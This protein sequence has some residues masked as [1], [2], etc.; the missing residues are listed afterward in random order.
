MHA[1]AHPVG[2][3]PMIRYLLALCLMLAAPA[4]AATW[5]DGGG[6]AAAPL[7][8]G[9]DGVWSV[10]PDKSSPN[11]SHATTCTPSSCNRTG[12]LPAPRGNGNPRLSPSAVF[13]KS[14]LVTG[15]LLLGRNILPWV[16]VGE[17]L[18]DWYK[19]A[20]L[21]PDPVT[22]EPGEMAGAQESAS[23][24]YYFGSGNAYIVA[25]GTFSTEAAAVQLVKSWNQVP[26]GSTFV[27][28]VYE[29]AY[30]VNGG[31]GSSRGRFIAKNNSNGVETQYCSTFSVA[32]GSLSQT[33]C[34][35][36]GTK[37]IMGNATGGLCP[38]GTFTPVSIATA[39]QRLNNADVTSDVLKRS[40]ED[41]LKAGGSLQDTGTHS[42]IGPSSVPG[43]TKTKTTTA[44][45]GTTQVTTVTN[46]YN[47]N[48]AGNT[49]TITTTELVQNPDGST[50][51]TTSD[52]P[53]PL[54]ADNPNSLACIKLG[55]VPTDQP[56]WETKTIAYQ[57]DSLGLPAACPAPWTGQLRG[58]T[59][60]FSYQPAC[61]VAPQVRLAILALTT[62]GALLMIITTV[63]T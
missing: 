8:Q 18:Y 25:E 31:C 17:A 12:D 57:A 1:G 41:I 7:T 45:N 20:N 48:Y 2:A 19:A 27:S 11:N 56:G 35:D 43:E 37:K 23:G 3:W 28:W 13:P 34:A 55:D 26:T 42:V 58:W 5:K 10:L 4:F 36:V 54:C 61:D 22:G 44:A 40:L 52:T 51:E 16:G 50:E 30:G 46:N 63:R 53:D 39:E 15:A 14:A 21:A 49:I 24:Y 29:P 59:L 47:Y 38:G 33:A 60:S 62:L 6:W 9:G 32:R